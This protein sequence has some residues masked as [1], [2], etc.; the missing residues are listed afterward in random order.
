LLLLLLLLL[1]PPVLPMPP[2][3]LRQWR[4]PRL[5]PTATPARWLVL[6]LVLLLGPAGHP[7]TGRCTQPPAAGRVRAAVSCAPRRAD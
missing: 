2:A 4:P 5:Q 6:L 7:L 3:A 1:L